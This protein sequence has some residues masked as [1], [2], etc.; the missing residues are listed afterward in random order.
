M[1]DEDMRYRLGNQ[2]DRQTV[3]LQSRLRG[4]F[5]DDA[6]IC[7][8]CKHATIFRQK[9]QNNRQVYCGML[10]RYM[11]T[12]IDECNEYRTVN[13]LSLSQ[14]ADIAVLIDMNDKK[15]GFHKEDTE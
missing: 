15:V 12:D 6:T 5:V 2:L 4:H 3:K 1:D 7:T 8:S 9:S 13:D 10:S 14:M 11:P